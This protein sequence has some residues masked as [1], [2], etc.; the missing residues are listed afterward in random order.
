MKK[1]L[2]INPGSS[3]TKIAVFNNLTPKY[4]KNIKHPL[5]KISEFNSISEQ[6]SF[7]KKLIL[8]LLKQEN[9]PIN[10][11]DA[12]IGR[13]GF[14]KPVESGV[15]RTNELMVDTLKSGCL[16][17]HASNLGGMLAHDIAKLSDK[18]ILSFI[19]DPVVVDEME[20]LARFSG[21]PEIPRLSIFHALNQKAVIRRYAK[22]RGIDISKLNIIVAHI[23]GGTSLGAHKQG[24]AI[25]V[26]NGLDGEGPFSTDRSGGVPIGQ[27]RQ[28]CFSGKYTHN[29]IK[30]KIKGKGGLIAYLGT[31]DGL[32]IEKR[33]DNGDNKAKKVY[34]AM[35]YQVAKEIGSLAT[36]LKGKVDAII[37]TGGFAYSDLFISWIKERVGFISEI[38]VYPGEDE[39]RALAEGAYYAL[40]NEMPINEYKE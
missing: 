21:I 39:M 15:I 22:E 28:L 38:I 27:L 16:G 11:F 6:F 9:I 40:N 14:I 17:E 31:I 8:N 18:E 13:G 35:A 23:G 36:V 29:E 33:I 2:V 12:I 30:L 19:L 34:E 5:E 32:E 10:S 24:K 4:L 20:E 37:L 3:S 1:I 7:R 25:D 26:N